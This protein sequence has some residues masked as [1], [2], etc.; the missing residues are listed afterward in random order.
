MFW[1]RRKPAVAC[2]TG[3]RLN[4]RVQLDVAGRSYLTRV[5]DVQNTELHVAAPLD[6]GW[7]DALSQHERAVLNVFSDSGFRRFATT[8]TSLTP[9]RVP[10]VV[11]AHVKDLGALDRRRYD[12]IAA[13]A[14][15]KYRM[16]VE[17]GDA[18]PWRSAV[19]GDVSG[20]GLRLVCDGSPHLAINDYVDLQLSLAH[21]EE[22]VKAVAQLA[23]ITGGSQNEPRHSFG[24]HFVV[25]HHADRMRVVDYVK[26]RR[27][28]LKSWR[29]RDG[30]APT[31]LTLR[32]R[33]IRGSD[34]G[35]WRRATTSDV[36]ASGLRVV[37]ESV[38]AC[39][40]GDLIDVELALPGQDT[41][42]TARGKIAWKSAAQQTGHPAMG[43]HFEAI[44][45]D[46]RVRIT[47]YVRWKLNSFQR[48]HN[49]LPVKD[50]LILSMEHRRRHERAPTGLPVR[51][52]LSADS[53][54]DWHSATTSDVSA[55]GLRIIN[56]HIG[57]CKAGDL[58]EVELALPGHESLLTTAGR[59]AWTTSRSD[60]QGY[61]AMGVHFDYISAADRAC[62]TEFVRKKLESFQPEHNRLRD[63]T[64][65]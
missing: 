60:R 61:P 46:D 14:P 5:E 17:K 31:D 11:L 42:V 30:R 51:Y 33:L 23:W 53:K 59:I 13:A 8:V 52:R 47:E 10:L 22:P 19:T 48:E 43:L 49:R 27:M 1:F 54:K 21:D 50:R 57:A 55:S 34:I 4:D 6:K 63:G 62:L 56:E 65:Q 15:V 35:D 58:I 41:A 2:F 36:S 9:G 25:I 16:K 29:R 24:V 37:D 18:M 7:Q 28:L 38:G 26:S 40:A 3:V 45:D 32:Y 12:R 44:S 20:S 64:K 39:K